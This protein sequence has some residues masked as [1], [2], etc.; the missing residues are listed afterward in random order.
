[1]MNI[2]KI[3]DG[4]LMCKSKLKYVFKVSVCMLSIFSCALFSGCCGNWKKEI[5]HKLPEFGH[6]NWILVV[7]EAYPSQ[8]SP[9]VKTIVT[10]EDQVEVLSYVLKEI[11]KSAHIRAVV[12]LDEELKSVIEDDAPGVAE[13]KRK[14]S[15]LLNSSNVKY[16]EHEKIIG[17]I[18]AAADMFNILVLKTDMRIPYTSVFLRLECGYWSEEQEHKRI[19]HQKNMAK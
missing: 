6:R 18:D 9:G 16:A 13:Y 15:E 8:V 14:L 19:E 17:D 1:M 11:D 12:F 4:T 10:N 3:E 5:S 7:D 2:D